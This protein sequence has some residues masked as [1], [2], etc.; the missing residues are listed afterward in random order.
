VTEPVRVLVVS[1]DPLVREGARFGFLSDVSVTFAVDAR[2]AWRVLEHEAPSVVVVDMQTGNAGGFAL[3][4]DMSESGRLA[5]V[6]T[7]ILLERPQDAWLARAAGARAYRVK[8]LSSGEL[9]RAVMG[10]AST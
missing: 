8:P 5:E 10:L 3:A 1:D 7:L 9:P 6:P 4:R 2:E